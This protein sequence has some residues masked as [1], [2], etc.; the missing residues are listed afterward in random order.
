M[1]LKLWDIYWLH[2]EAKTQF[3]RL[4]QKR[5]PGSPPRHGH[6][7]PSRSPHSRQHPPPPSERSPLRSRRS[8]SGH[9][10]WDTAFAG[11]ALHPG[12]GWELAMRTPRMQSQSWNSGLVAV[13]VAAPCVA[14][15]STG[16]ASASV[17]AEVRRRP[18]AADGGRC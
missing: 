5:S 17:A 3:L 4:S 8:S 13:W 7:Q 10:D 16:M 2:I 1:L 11:D 14:G 12:W 15:R 18:A 9:W 6:S